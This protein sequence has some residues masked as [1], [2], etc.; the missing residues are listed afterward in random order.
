MW[1]WCQLLFCMKIIEESCEY[2]STVNPRKTEP[3]LTE[4]QINRTLCTNW[5]T[6]GK[7]GPHIYCMTNLKTNQTTNWSCIMM[8]YFPP[9][10]HRKSWSVHTVFRVHNTTT[11][12]S[13]TQGSP[14]GTQLD[15]PSGIS[16]QVVW[17]I[18]GLLYCTLLL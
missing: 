6:L 16:P 9:K 10:Y 5:T 17:F 12:A 8:A 14:S 15:E 7:Q 2:Y 1:Y 18:E 4:F 11:T 3:H 13:R